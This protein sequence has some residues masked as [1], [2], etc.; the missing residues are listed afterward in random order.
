[1]KSL[2]KWMAAPSLVAAITAMPV[3][4]HHSFA[5]FDQT[6]ES[7]L[8]SLVVMRFE[9]TNPHVFV[10]GPSGSTTYTLECS[11]PNLWDIRGGTTTR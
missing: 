9:W 11:S 8:K 2:A 10:I 4:N 6:K 7:K 3:M 1:M 5:M